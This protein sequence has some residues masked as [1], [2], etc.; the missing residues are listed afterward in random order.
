MKLTKENSNDSKIKVGDL[1]HSEK[2][3]GHIAIIIGKDKEYYYVAQAIW[4]DEVGVVV[5][6]F[7]LDELYKEFPHVVLMEEYYK[8][9]GYLTN[10]W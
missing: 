1:L 3:G 2:L 6:K 10:M 4:F 9:D 7:K 5:T 8:N